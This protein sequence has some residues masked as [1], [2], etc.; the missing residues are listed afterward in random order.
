MCLFR[1]SHTE[2]DVP[3]FLSE[4][5]EMYA[6]FKNVDLIIEGPEFEFDYSYFLIDKCDDLKDLEKGMTLS[7]FE[8]ELES[9]DMDMEYR[10]LTRLNC[11][12]IHYENLF[13]S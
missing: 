8:E 9:R 13:K 7:K 1:L 4:Y 11:H 3:V 2:S 5:N 6:K 12:K 10:L